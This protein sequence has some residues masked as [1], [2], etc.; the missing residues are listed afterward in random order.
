MPQQT[1]LGKGT[2]LRPLLAA[3]RQ[4]IEEYAA[5]HQ[6]HWIEDSSNQCDDFDRNYLRNQISP[7]IQARWPSADKTISRAGKH[8]ADAEKF[9]QQASEALFLPLYCS[10]Q[11]SLVISGLLKY[12]R[13]RQ[14]LILRRWFQALQ[15]RPPPTKLI[16]QILATVITARDDANPRLSYQHGAVRRYRGRLYWQNHVPEIDPSVSFPWPAD[17]RNIR[18]PDNSTLTA[19]LSNQPGVSGDIWRSAEI[20]VAYR[21]GGERIKL[22][23]RSGS[24]A[25]KKLFQETG[26]PPWQ[27]VNIP[28]IFVD[29]QLAA[30]ADKWISSEFFRPAGSENIRLQW[31]PVGRVSRQ[32]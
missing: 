26:I 21:Q 22:P 12:D 3:S 18:L 1:Q 25:L 30:V 2:L 10:E 11:R 9:I 32:A 15:L 5:R 17:Q 7:L 14:Q 16:Q 13:Y 27:R 20:S 23:G 24:H 4:S 6:L 31:Q 29:G 19:S 28:L 8:C